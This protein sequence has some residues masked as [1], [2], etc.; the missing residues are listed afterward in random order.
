MC[1]G[2]PGR[3]DLPHLE[4]RSA[5]VPGPIVVEYDQSTDK[6]IITP[7]PVKVPV[8]PPSSTIDMVRAAV[9][10]STWTFVSVNKLKPPEFTWTLAADRKSITIVDTPNGKHDHPYTV[11]ILLA[12]GTTQKTSPKDTEDT[13]KDGKGRGAASPTSGPVVTGSPPMIM[14]E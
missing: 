7:K 2:H 5:H 11:T 3:A 14:N 6:W 10:S 12:D 1:C 4:R 13:Q 8:P 9:P